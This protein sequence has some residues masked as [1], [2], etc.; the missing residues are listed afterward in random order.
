MWDGNVEFDETNSP[1]DAAVKRSHAARFATIVPAHSASLSFDRQLV[2]SLI[3]I[4]SRDDRDASQ[5]DWCPLRLCEK[6]L[7]CA[8]RRWT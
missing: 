1:C 8:E 7:L 4:A 6:A 3:S 2:E 5:Q